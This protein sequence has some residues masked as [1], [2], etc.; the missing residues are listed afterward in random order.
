LYSLQTQKASFP[1][2]YYDTWA[3]INV[4]LGGYD[5]TM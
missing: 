3:T 2:T 5:G 4:Y 1:F